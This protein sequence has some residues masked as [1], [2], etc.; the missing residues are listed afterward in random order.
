MGTCWRLTRFIH[1]T[2]QLPWGSQVLQEHVPHVLLE[3]A[4]KFAQTLEPAPSWHGFGAWQRDWVEKQQESGRA[5]SKGWGMEEGRSSWPALAW[6]NRC[7]FTA[8]E[9]VAGWA[10]SLPGAHPSSVSRG[11][12]TDPASPKQIPR[13]EPRDIPCHP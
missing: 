10:N 7:A 11:L 3:T 1:V 9:S 4:W 5:L 6:Q 12:N 2:P 13:K 8:L